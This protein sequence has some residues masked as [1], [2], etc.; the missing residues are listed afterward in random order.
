[1]RFAE[2]MG[3]MSGAREVAAAMGEA[4]FSRRFAHPHR[5]TATAFDA[6][7]EVQGVV[8]PNSSGGVCA[9][10][11]EMIWQKSADGKQSKYSLCYAP[12][13]R[14]GGQG[15]TGGS[16][17]CDANSYVTVEG[18]RFCCR[19]P[20]ININGEKMQA[21]V[22]VCGDVQADFDAAAQKIRY[23]RGP[24]FDGTPELQNALEDSSM[25]TNL[26]SPIGTQAMKDGSEWK[27]LL[28]QRCK[29]RDGTLISWPSGRAEMC[30]TGSQPVHGAGYASWQCDGTYKKEHRLHCCSV[31][32]KMKCVPN[33]VDQASAMKCNC[34]GVGGSGWSE[35]AEGKEDLEKESEVGGVTPSIGLSPLPVLLLTSSGVPGQSRKTR[36]PCRRGYGRQLGQSFL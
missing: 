33:L 16:L 2:P 3:G 15:P 5:A 32:G 35:D 34:P 6:D 21:K 27:L 12:A 14:H 7:S 8:N 20:R 10:E 23:V 25:G 31:K 1:M 11:G 4:L 13:T 19:N 18:P 28:G 26:P 30:P 9:P 24:S 29:G 22:E 17:N 36:R